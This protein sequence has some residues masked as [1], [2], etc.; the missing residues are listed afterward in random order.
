[1]PTDLLGDQIPATPAMDAP[2]PWRVYCMDDYPTYFVARS[3]AEAK[4]AAA[5]AWGDDPTLT[6][7]AYE[8]SDEALLAEKINVADEGEPPVFQ[9][10]RAYLDELI[11]GGLSQPDFFASAE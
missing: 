3:L 1:M 11:A 9:T 6:E 10:F 5:E 2:L 4:A 7:D 8:L